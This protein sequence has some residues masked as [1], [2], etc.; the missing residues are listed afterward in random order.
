MPSKV[1]HHGFRTFHIHPPNENPNSV[2]NKIEFCTGLQVFSGG[3][4]LCDL[5]TGLWG[6]RVFGGNASGSW[7]GNSLWVE[8]TAIKVKLCCNQGR[9][10]RLKYLQVQTCTHVCL[11]LFTNHGNGRWK[12][13][14]SVVTKNRNL[15]EYYWL[16]RRSQPM[17]DVD[18][19]RAK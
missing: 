10:T 6:R 16:I 19:A 12:L 1:G 8:C 13:G 18:C 5:V 3:F 7:R 9:K 11:I 14:N 2:L 17:G 15:L 4:F